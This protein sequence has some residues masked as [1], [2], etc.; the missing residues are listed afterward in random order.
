M[1]NSI[2]LAKAYIN[3]KSVKILGWQAAVRLTIAL[4]WVM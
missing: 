3:D 2:P 4:G 1:T